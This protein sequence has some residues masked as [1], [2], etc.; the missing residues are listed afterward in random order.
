VIDLHL[1]FSPTH[2]HMQMMEIDAEPSM[3]ILF[4]KA[5]YGHLKSGFLKDHHYGSEAAELTAISSLEDCV[6]CCILT[7]FGAG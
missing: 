1:P 7:Y 5:A 4:P 2:K 3:M 6:P